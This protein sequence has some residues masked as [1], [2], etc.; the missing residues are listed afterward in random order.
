LVGETRFE[1]AAPAFQRHRFSTFSNR[2]V[3]HGALFESLYMNKRTWLS[4]VYSGRLLNVKL[5][6]FWV[7]IP[8]ILSWL[9]IAAAM[10]A[11]VW[12]GG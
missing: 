2:Y 8:F 5:D 11:A 1:L 9:L 6:D 12:G 10:I 7:I 3:T 4:T